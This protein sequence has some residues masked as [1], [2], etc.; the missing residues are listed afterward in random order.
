MKYNPEYLAANRE[1][2]DQKVAVHR[3]SSFY[4]MDEFAAGK[5]VLD[6]IATHGVGDLSGK[7]VLHLQCHFGLDTMSLLR[8]GADSAVG[9]DLSPEAVKLAREL[10]EQHG[11]RAQFIE[12][13][14]YKTS[15]VID[16][17]FDL[18]FSTFGAIPWLPDLDRWAEVVVQHLKP[19]GT[20]YFAEFHPTLYLFNFEN[21]RVEYDYFNRAYAEEI[22]GTYAEPSA[23]MRATEH[24]WTHS[25]DEVV[26][27]LLKRGLVLEKFA[28]H[29]WSPFN[30]FSNMVEKEPGRY[31]FGNFENVRIP[32]VLE[33]KFSRS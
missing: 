22:I 6:K 8:L 9:I 30:C 21:Q 25:I 33:L 16:E 10:A 15:E 12:S 32:H 3:T 27:P 5:S 31:V 18:V 28:E 1:L 11:E 2:W 26:R 14:V 29:D 17:Q 13:D 7:R 4:R 24:F 19:G 20:F 23:D